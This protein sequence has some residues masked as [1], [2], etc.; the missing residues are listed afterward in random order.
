MKRIILTERQFSELILLEDKHFPLFLK[1]L[2]I[3]ATSFAK[4]AIDDAIKYNHTSWNYIMQTPECDYTEN[5]V[6]NVNI[7]N[8]ENA[9]VNDYEGYYIGNYINPVKEKFDY[10]TIK[11]IVPMNTNSGYNPAFIDMTIFHEVEHMYDDWMRQINNGY[12]SIDDK[13]ENNIINLFDDIEKNYKDNKF[14]MGVAGIAYLSIKDEEKAF[15]T[16]TYTELQRVNCTRFNYQE[17]IKETYSYKQYNDIIKNKLPIIKTSSIEDLNL[18]IELCK[19]YKDS[20]IPKFSG[21]YS[22]YRNKLIKWGE[23]TAHQFI[24]KFGGVLTQ[25]LENNIKGKK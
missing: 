3:D 16:Q 2:M 23:F 17:K 24:K 25:Y 11:L 1:P 15:L 18:L 5:I 14:L 6:F 12:A 22:Q 8:I 19:K 21:N 7:T 10:I 13:V 9:G 20:N 4:K